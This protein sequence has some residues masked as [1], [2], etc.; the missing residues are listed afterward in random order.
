MFDW[1]KEKT[2]GRALFG[3]N[4]LFGQAFGTIA[5]AGISVSA[6]GVTIGGQNRPDPSGAEREAELLKYGI[7][8]LF[9]YMVFKSFS[10]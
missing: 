6:S 1:I 8:G 4:S 5:D 10:K 2:S 3:E 9:G 7:I